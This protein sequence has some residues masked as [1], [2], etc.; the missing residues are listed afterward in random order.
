MK[1]VLKSVL[2][3]LLATVMVISF[4]G[5]GN[6]GDTGVSSASDIEAVKLDKFQQFEKELLDKGIEF[7]IVEKM[8]AMIGAKEGYGYKF[9][10]ESSVEL[11]LFDKGSDAYK[12]AIKTSKVSIESLGMTMR[13]DFNDD[14]CI[15]YN[16]EVTN[17]SDIETIFNSLK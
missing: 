11:Y 15:Y 13:V 10:D 9:N 12:E 2:S 6:N 16:G 14:I 5:C 17:R 1:K 3:F 7:E 4:V 8:G